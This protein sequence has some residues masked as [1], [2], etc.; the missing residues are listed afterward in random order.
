MNFFNYQLFK[1]YTSH[2]NSFIYF[3]WKQIKIQVIKKEIPFTWS[4]NIH[5]IAHRHFQVSKRPYFYDLSDMEELAF[6]EHFALKE[7]IF[8]DIGANVGMYSTYLS[9][10]KKITC[11]QFEPN[12]AARKLNIRI[13]IKNR[14]T[15]LNTLLSVA[16]SD[17]ISTD[18]FTDN[19]DQQ[20]KLA[21][22]VKNSV[23]I[24]VKTLDYFD[25]LPEPN[26]I[27]IDSEGEEYKILC[28]AENLFQR[29]NIKIIVIEFHIETY[30]QIKDYL[31]KFGFIQI[32]FDKS[33]NTFYKSE[34]I[35][36][37]G[38]MIFIKEHLL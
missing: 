15:N 13:Q 9:V 8:Y 19:L 36:L 12:A 5:W 32:R 6:L 4:E 24:Q 3:I 31:Q 10:K 37:S 38:N 11:V 20:N 30:K 35:T 14:I 21:T 1:K 18:W 23:K 33:S 28:G 25:Q 17:R 34:T 27:K 2:K 22:Q 7:D 26:V 29:S 16:L